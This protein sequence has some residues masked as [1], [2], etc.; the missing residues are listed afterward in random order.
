[1]TNPNDPAFPCYH[2]TAPSGA[3]GLTRREVFAALA[4]QGILANPHTMEAVAPAK[5]EKTVEFLC[6]CAAQAADALIAA[7]NAEVIQ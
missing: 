6:E 2:S 3:H 7:L 4:L 1:M 5:G